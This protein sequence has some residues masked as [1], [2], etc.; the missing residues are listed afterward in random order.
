MASNNL[1]LNPPF[2]FTDENYQIWCLKMQDFLEAYELWETVTEDK[3]LTALRAFPTFAQIKSNNEEKAKKSKTKSLMQNAVED[4]VFYR[5][6]ACKT[7]KEALDRLKEEYQGSDR[8]RQMQVLNLKREFDS[9]NMQEDETI[10]KY[11]DRIS[12]IV[13]NIR[14]LSEEFTDK[15]IVEKFLVTLP[16][17]F[18]SKISSIEESKNLSKHSLGKQQFHQ[19][20]KGKHDGGNNSGDVKQKFPPWKYCKRN[21]HLEKYFWWRVGAICDNC[22]QTGHVSKL[23]KSIA[24]ASGALQ[25]QVAEAADAR[26]EKL[27]AV[28]YF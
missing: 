15:R 27:F 16:E 19:K 12:L 7:A 14:L 22:K 9:L 4:N 18:E 24:K 13:N 20:N 1:P 21:T 28:S 2:T 3:P 23:C 10:S 6:M 5:I 8:T 26:E 11:A 25:A 17:R